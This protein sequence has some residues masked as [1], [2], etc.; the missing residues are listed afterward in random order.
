MNRKEKRKCEAYVY[1]IQSNGKRKLLTPI[2]HKK[3][4]E[5]CSF[6]LKIV[7]FKVFF[8]FLI[9]MIIT[10]MIATIYIYHSD[11][12]SRMFVILVDFFGFMIAK[13][14]EVANDGWISTFFL[15]FYLRDNYV[16]FDML[17]R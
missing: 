5:N 8:R 15:F 3:G 10:G 13:H 7:Y 1:V 17:N 14:I 4:V 2:K 9:R 16:K 12:I 6:R 11:N